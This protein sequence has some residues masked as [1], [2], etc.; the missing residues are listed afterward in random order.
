MARRQGL[1]THNPAEAVELPNIETV[2]R[3]TFTPAEVRLL[4]EATEDAEWKNIILL[5]YFTGA[6]LINC[7]SPVTSK[8]TTLG[9][10]RSLLGFKILHPG[11][12]LD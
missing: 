12:S 4:V 6:R 11:F 1:I 10:N 2:E 5:G 8:G 9:R 7:L 3:G